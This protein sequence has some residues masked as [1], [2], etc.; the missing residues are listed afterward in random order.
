MAT[1]LLVMGRALLAT[2]T[3]ATTPDSA[4]VWVSGPFSPDSSSTTRKQVSMECIAPFDVDS[5]HICSIGTKAIT[6]R[7]VA[8]ELGATTSRHAP[9]PYRN[10][11]PMF[12][13]VFRSRGDLIKPV[14]VDFLE[15]RRECHSTLFA[16]NSILHAIIGVE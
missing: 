2:R 7:P 11:A 1:C 9:I 15:S 3:G 13:R 10:A 6:D 4:P 14:W 16:L 12:R 5:C 8:P